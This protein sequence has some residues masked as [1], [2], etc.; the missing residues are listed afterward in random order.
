MTA[1][2]PDTMDLFTETV[3]DG[4]YLYDGKWHPLKVIEET[5]KV[6]FAEDV[7]IKIE[8]TRNGVLIDRDFNH[9]TAEDLTPYVPNEYLKVDK[10]QPGK[11]YSLA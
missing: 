10:T 8:M 2:N 3:K 1:L 7:N 4:K 6:R 9:G 11:V 5:I